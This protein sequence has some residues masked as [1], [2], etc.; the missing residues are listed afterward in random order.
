MKDAYDIIV[1]GGGVYGMYSASFLARNKIRVLI[2]E[3][4]NRILGRASMINQARVHNGLHYPRGERTI[5]SILKFK[6]RFVRDFGF[7]INKNFDM[8]YGIACNSKTPVSKFREIMF[9]YGIHATEISPSAYFNSGKLDSLFKTS[10]YSFDYECIFNYYKQLIKDLKIDVAYNVNITDV[11]ESN[12]CYR[13]TYG[14]TTISCNGIINATYSSINGI[15][16]IF[17][18][19]V[20]DVDYELCEIAL[21]KVPTEILN[22]GFTL[23]DGDFFSIMP[24]GFSALHSLSSVH[25]TPHNVSLNGFFHCMSK[26]D[27]CMPE[28]FDNCNYCQYHPK[29]A[30]KK[31]ESLY[32]E[33]MRPSIHNI[34]YVKSYYTIKPILR[35]SY[36]T[37]DRITKVNVSSVF[38]I[39]L[40]VLAGKFSTFYG[41][42]PYLNDIVR[43]FGKDNK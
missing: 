37:D 26:T 34:S 32:K 21:C 20:F 24:F 23:M 11:V 4:D 33:Y 19:D 17:E 16:R 3:R 30:F 9:K 40:S 14:N 18:K 39:Y 5:R 31:M 8:Y 25:Y 12:G 28:N 38:P 6:D 15:N 41:L 13:V 42:D 27:R 43:K 29:S 7:C 22:S 1:I 2:V 35:D 10:E 36:R